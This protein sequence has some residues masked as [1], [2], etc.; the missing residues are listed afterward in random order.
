MNFK[1][2]HSFDPATGF[3]AGPIQLDDSDL[4]P[5]E[6][7]VFLIPGDCLEDG[8]P[9]IPE[10]FR[11]VAQG[12]AWSLVA[13]PVVAPPTPPSL[14]ELR[15]TLTEQATARRWAVET[16]G[17]TLPNGV[18]VLTG[19]EDQTRITSVIAGMEAAGFLSVDF[20]AASGWVELSLEEMQTLRTF[21]AGHVRACYSAERAHHTAIAALAT[22][23]AAQT[24]D[25]TAGWPSPVITAAPAA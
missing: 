10:G 14:Q 1:T 16:G 3:Y 15:A 18:K 2:V 9:P 5:L 17:I 13:I 21:V 20:K 6:E 8:P 25:L 22:V 12:N 11:A 4:S 19:I 24:Y 23:A 7:G